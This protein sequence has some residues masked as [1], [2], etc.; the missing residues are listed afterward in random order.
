MTKEEKRA[1][2]KKLVAELPHGKGVS[3][4]ARWCWSHESTVHKWLKTSWPGST[5]IER[6]MWQFFHRDLDERGNVIEVA[7]EPDEQRAI[8]EAVRTK[9][10]AQVG[11]VLDAELLTSSLHREMQRLLIQQA[12]IAHRVIYAD[13]K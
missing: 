12:D 11:E 5:E 10:L 13:D 2:L 7:Q 3:K 9:V 4:I 8:A 1:L 6:R